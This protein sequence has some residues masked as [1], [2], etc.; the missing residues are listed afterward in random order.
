MPLIL[1]PTSF[2]ADKIFC[3][4]DL[5]S[6]VPTRK[7]HNLVIWPKN[8][9]KQEKE[10]KENVGFFSVNSSFFLARKKRNHHKALQFYLIRSGSSRDSSCPCE[11]KNL[12]CPDTDVGQNL[13]SFIRKETRNLYWDRIFSGKME[14]SY[15]D[16]V[17]FE[18]ERKTN[19]R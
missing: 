7:W 2:G 14:D 18:R 9:A 6:G 15:G 11:T 4:V 16:Y 10:K 12:I 5:H 3:F 13:D 17:F 8:D 19:S 1:Y